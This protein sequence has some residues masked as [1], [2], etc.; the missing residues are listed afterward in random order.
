MRGRRPKDEGAALSEAA[1]VMAPGWDADALEAAATRVLPSG[2]VRL[3]LLEEPLPRK[4]DTRKV[5]RFQLL[6]YLRQRS[7]RAD[8]GSRRAECKEPRSDQALLDAISEVLGRSEPAAPSRSFA[9]LG[10]D[11]VAALRAAARARS[12]GLDVSA[13]DLLSAPS[14]SAVQSK[15]LAEHP[16]KRPRASSSK[17]LTVATQQE[18]GDEFTDQVGLP[19]RATA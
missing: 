13:L 15:V 3:H 4:Q 7:S 9:S 6:Q 14:I 17:E 12:R 19:W 8:H 1:V 2:G 5:D 10:G 18:L 11:S 16:A